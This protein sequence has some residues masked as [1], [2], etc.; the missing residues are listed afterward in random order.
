MRRAPDVFQARRSKENLINLGA[1][2]HKLGFF[3]EAIA[4]YDR[5]IERD[6]KNPLAWFGKGSALA[7]IGK[8][9]EAVE[10]YLNCIKFAESNPEYAERVSKAKEYIRELQTQIED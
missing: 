10:T 9:K 8:S 1:T 6:P 3:N 7:S 5:V 4:C 2:L